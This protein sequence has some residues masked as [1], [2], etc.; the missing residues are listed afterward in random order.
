M[1]PW[2]TTVWDSSGDS[3]LAGAKPG[4]FGLAA[5]TPVNVGALGGWADATVAALAATT[6]TGKAQKTRFIGFLP[7]VGYSRPDPRPAS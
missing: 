4:D 3:R 6:A 1:A 2:A 5:D 7:R